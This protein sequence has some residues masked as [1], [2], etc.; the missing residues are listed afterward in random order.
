VTTKDDLHQ[1]VDQLDEAAA[2]EL[3]EYARWLAA[4]ED[5]PLTEEELAR[6]EAGEAEI[7]RGDYVTLEDV[8]RRLEL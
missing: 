2:D 3:L 6:V 7:R 4:E 8:K 5:E 1:L